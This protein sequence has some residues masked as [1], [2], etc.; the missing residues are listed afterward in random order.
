MFSESQW[1]D[2]GLSEAPKKWVSYIYMFIF[3]CFF[4]VV[5]V[6]LKK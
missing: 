4:I 3:V 5:E 2:Y 1:Q 6:F